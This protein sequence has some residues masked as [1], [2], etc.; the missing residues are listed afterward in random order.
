MGWLESKYINLLSPR[1][2]Q[3]T[4]KSNNLYNFRCPLC[5]DSSNNKR[6]LRGYIFEKKG[7]Y[8]FFCHKCN[9]S[10]SFKNIL[11]RLDPMLHDDYVKEILVES[12]SPTP[13]EKTTFE[14]TRPKFQTMGAL[15]KLKKVSTLKPGHPVKSY[16]ESRLIPSQYHYKLF[17]C[18]LFKSWVNTIIPDK[19]D[20]ESLERDAPRL[21]IPL[22]NK[23]GEMFGFQGRSYKKNAAVR[24]IT[25][26]TDP[27]MA[28]IYG[29]DTVD[30]SKDIYCF[31]G[32][33][34]SMFIPNSIATC[35]GEASRELSKAG[36]PKDKLI[37]VY[38]NEPRNEHTVQKIFKSIEYGYRVCIWPE[39]V[40]E[41][42]INDMVMNG[43]KPLDIINDS[44]Y[45][46]LMAKLRLQEWKRV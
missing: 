23:E 20:T 32:P 6:K 16:V 36:I 22:L 31:E 38:D 27:D 24:Y 25:I 17:H 4:R 3:F 28:R 46:N 34:D 2:E 14:F 13:K 11:K 40:A 44:V 1:L 9:A 41:K 39:T 29:L 7:S 43:L 26:M 18:K 8:F 42:D 30:T 45:S 33:I 37:M 5:G 21:V 12:G 10:H 15:T 19:F 35:G